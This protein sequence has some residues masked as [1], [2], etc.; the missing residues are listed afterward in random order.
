MR[1]PDWNQIHINASTCGVHVSNPHAETLREASKLELFFVFCYYY[2][3][4]YSKLNAVLGASQASH[5]TVE[6]MAAL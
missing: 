2:I 5:T 3:A 4:L 1:I 6:W